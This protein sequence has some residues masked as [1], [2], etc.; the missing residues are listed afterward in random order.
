MNIAKRVGALEGKV[1]DTRFESVHR[2]IQ[3]AGQTED[4]AFDAY[5]RVK[6]GPNDFV[7]V[8]EILAWPTN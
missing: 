5:G 8:R 4:E 7:I 1:G 3:R 2:I 6:M